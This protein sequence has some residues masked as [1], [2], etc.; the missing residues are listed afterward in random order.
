MIAL[1]SPPKRRQNRNYVSLSFS[2]H[3]TLETP[4]NRRATELGIS[5]SE[6]VSKLIERDL[7]GSGLLDEQTWLNKMSAPPRVRREPE[8]AKAQAKPK[9]GRAVVKAKKK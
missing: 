5:R 7:I 8:P 6:Y 1:K 4:L 9:P 3:P 2:A